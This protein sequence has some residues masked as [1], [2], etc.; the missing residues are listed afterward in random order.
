MTFK[1]YTFT[2][3]LAILMLMNM[4]LDYNVICEYLRVEPFVPEQFG[5]GNLLAIAVAFGVALALSMLAQR[6]ATERVS[7][8][9]RVMAALLVA[10]G[11]V[12]L[13]VAAFRLSYDASSAGRSISGGMMSSLTAA[14]VFYAGIMLAMLLG[15]AAASFLDR[16]SEYRKE[17]ATLEASIVRLESDLGC[18]DEQIAAAAEVVN[19]R[20]REAYAAVNSANETV[21]EESLKRAGELQNSFVGYIAEGEKARAEH[22]DELERRL[23]GLLLPLPEVGGVTASTDRTPKKQGGSFRHPLSGANTAASDAA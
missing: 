22:A 9:S 18:I 6:A 23:G 5:V 19:A 17:A 4:A 7:G 13:I 3:K 14:D 16:L 12:S 1:E 8:N 2:L 21:Y 20:I 15:E 10:C 11:V